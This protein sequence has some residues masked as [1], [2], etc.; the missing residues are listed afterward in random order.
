MERSWICNLSVLSFTLR[1]VTQYRI[2]T[3]GVGLLLCS[4]QDIGHCEGLKTWN[5]R[6]F[7]TTLFLLLQSQPK[8]SG[9]NKI[10]SMEYVW[11]ILGCLLLL[12]AIN[13]PGFFKLL[14]WVA[15]V[16]L[17]VYS[18]PKLDFM[19]QIEA[20]ETLAA[21]LFLIGIFQMSVSFTEY[22]FLGVVVL[23]E[24]TDFVIFLL[25][26]GVMITGL[27]MIL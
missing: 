17:L 3:Y 21:S 25:G 2:I 1:N 10:S 22:K 13:V 15:S 20:E 11:F 16:G 7:G 5:E 6:K 14:L 18:M 4:F 27:V 9:E 19:A 12:A 8:V 24:I 26:L 23:R